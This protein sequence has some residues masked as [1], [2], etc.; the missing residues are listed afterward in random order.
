MLVYL[1]KP[2]DVAVHKSRPTKEEAIA[3]GLAEELVLARRSIASKEQAAASM[4]LL[5]SGQLEELERKKSKAAE[6][7]KLATVVEVAIEQVEEAIEKLDGLS[8][9][10]LYCRPAN[11]KQELA[12]AQVVGQFVE[13]AEEEAAGQVATEQGSGPSM[14][15]LV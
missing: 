4:E 10:V 3:E 6:E 11:E 7:A 8:R 5:D 9:V 15:S 2:V 12:V 14:L 13:Q 1:A